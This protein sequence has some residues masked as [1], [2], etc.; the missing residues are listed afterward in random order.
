MKYSWAK[1]Y[2]KT[3]SNPPRPLL[4]QALTYTEKRGSVLDVGAGALVDTAYLLEEGFG[5]V[6]ALDADDTSL[7][8]SLALKDKRL[9]FVHKSFIEYEYPVE[10]YDVVNGQYAFSFIPAQA[11]PRV[12]TALLRSVK[13]G[14]ILV[15][16]IFGDR[17]GWNVEGD[18]KTFLTKDECL[19]YFADWEI[20]HFE[21]KER[22]D[23]T[24]LGVP[25][26][27][28]EFDII[29]RRK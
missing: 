15:G 9:I 17:D 29:A 22:D 14:G 7:A 3:K 10:V 23:T 19:A 25:K 20:L 2:E 21:E 24:A 12:F 27:W 28:H 13:L 6:V 16:N 5:S 18:P 4:V 8:L 11:F 26:H 1:Y